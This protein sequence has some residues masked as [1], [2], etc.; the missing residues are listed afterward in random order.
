[1]LRSGFLLGVGGPAALLT[2]FVL[3]SVRASADRLAIPAITLTQASV[4][5]TTYTPPYLSGSRAMSYDVGLT[6]ASAARFSSPPRI[7]TQTAPSVPASTGPTASEREAV[8]PRRFTREGCETPLSS[9]V[10]PE[11]R[12]MVPGRCMV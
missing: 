12:R 6:T 10:G 7:E 3:P 9:L 1:M 4:P 11:A 8:K 5:A 2:L